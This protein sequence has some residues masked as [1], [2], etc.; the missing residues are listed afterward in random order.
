MAFTLKFDP[1]T[2]EHLGV[3]MYS[4]LPPALAELISNSYDADASKVSIDFFEQNGTPTSISVTDDG[5]GMSALEIQENFLVIGRN[6]RLKQGDGP[7]VRF[8]RL[9]TGKKGLGKL[10]L[11][12]LAREITIDTIQNERRNRFKLNWDALLSS[13]DSYSPIVEI[14][15]KPAQGKSSGTTIQL[16]S[17]KRQSAFDL[18]SLANS[19]SKIF[20]VDDL[21]KVSLSD[22]RGTDVKITNDRRYGAVPVQFSWNEQDLIDRNEKEFGN[23]SISLLTTEKPIPPGSGLRG[24]TIFSRGKLVNAPEYFSTSSSSQFYQYLSGSVQADFI[25]LIPED[26]I[27]T[28]R[29][30]L[31]WDHP[32]LVQFRDYLDS[33]IGNV[34]QDWRRKRAAAKESAVEHATGVNT[35]AWF[36]ALPQSIRPTVENIV[37]QMVGNEEISETAIPIV[38]ALHELIPEYPLLH[39]R[40][41]HSSIRDGVSQFY[42]N[43]Q[44]G[45]AADQGCKLFA[46]RI[47][48]I[49]GDNSIDGTD[50]ASVFS[51]KIG[52]DRRTVDTSPRISIND[53]SSA[54]LRNMQDGQQ[55]LTRGLMAG[56]R[57]PVNHAPISKVVP[58]LISEIDCLN[59]LSLIS[60][61][62]QK[63]DYADATAGG[64]D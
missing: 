19:L 35:G 10:A 16:A 34:A 57:N 64:V 14:D 23:L 41:L 60:Y 32:R 61:L 42:I 43:Q 18:E 62:S 4:T 9:P 30:S 56:F 8:N 22:G 6:R 37:K 27:S 54:S 53:L 28:N 50:L 39:W 45:L 12:G 46:E 63:L 15:N 31:N 21:F 58:D 44:Y 25:D 2:I 11:F 20:I 17:L 52:S 51:F 49:T 24:V 36:A 3:K 47:R 29:Q 26:V 5:T 1:H 48:Y 33:I 7:S 59:I 40:H 38:R 13:G 55:H